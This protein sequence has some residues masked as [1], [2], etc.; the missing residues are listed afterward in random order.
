MS[1]RECQNLV[2]RLLDGERLE[3][4]PELR[5][6]LD[7]CTDCRR[8]FAAARTLL[9]GLRQLPPAPGPT[10][11]ASRIVLAAERD[12]EARRRRVWYRWY[13][14]VALAAALFLFIG[15]GNLVTWWRGDLADPGTVAQKKADREL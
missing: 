7:H 12:R 10:T 11:P 6:H 5:G 4:S 1:C 8:D 13:A 14:T 2:Q 15:F 9:T 3:P